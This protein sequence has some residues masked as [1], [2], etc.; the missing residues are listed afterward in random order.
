MKNF[1]PLPGT[2][3][4]IACSGHGNYTPHIIDLSLYYREILALR[5]GLSTPGQVPSVTN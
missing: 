1:P 5:F 4:S 3:S 2:K